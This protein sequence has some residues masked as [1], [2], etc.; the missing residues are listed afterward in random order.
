MSR[1]IALATT[2]VL[3]GLAS[4]CQDSSTVS[5]P[6]DPPAPSLRTVNNPDG[7]GAFVIRFQDALGVAFSGPDETLSVVTG[8]SLDQLA[9]LCAG[10]SFTL[11]PAT[12][13]LVFRPDGSIHQI[14]R[15]KGVTILVFAGAFADFCAEPP[16]AVGTGNYTNTDNDVSISGNR[17][18][19]FGFRL[20]GSVVD[21]SG[22][23]HHLLAR[24]RAQVT[25]SGELRELVSDIKL[26]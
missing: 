16:L 21:A 24:Y 17:A 19:S 2:L 23:R 5:E 6:A 18:N 3:G 26:N 20:R 1:Y 11:E 25:R 12:D 15:A 9:A 8:V 14:F 4:A 22:D 7:P 10:E 13:Q